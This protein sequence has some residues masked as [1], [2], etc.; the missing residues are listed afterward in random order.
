MIH[1]TTDLEPFL[2]ELSEKAGLAILEQYGKAQALVHKDDQSPLT[3][4][5]LS[6]HSIIHEG[7][8]GISPHVPVLSEE[9]EPVDPSERLQWE[10]YWLV[11]PLDGTK[12]FLKQNG[13][14]T[15]N[16]ALIHHSEPV[17]GVV[18]VPVRK[19]TYSGR[20][21]GGA[22]KRSGDGHTHSLK[23]VR[24][25]PS[26]FPLRVLGSRSHPSSELDAFLKR[27]GPYEMMPVGSSLKFMKIA[28]GSA[29]LYPRLGP[30]SEW[31]TAAAQAI[32]EAAGGHVISLEGVP[33]RYNT[34]ESLLNPHFL[35]YGD[36]DVHSIV[37]G[38]QNPGKPS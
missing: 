6:A 5:D 11:D 19:D 29:D 34:H 14:F 26:P 37:G 16:I 17:L 9:S 24:P 36:M 13:E 21:G 28:E 33:I 4:A 31:D 32:V 15:V 38:V 22:R 3:L 12:E 25:R 10:T 8:K 20:K 23:T 1:L 30:T 18:H 7:L 2:V 35:A 27:I